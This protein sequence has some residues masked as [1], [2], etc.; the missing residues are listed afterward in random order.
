[1]RKTQQEVRASQRIAYKNFLSQF[2]EEKKQCKNIR[3]LVRNA[4][5]ETEYEKY[6]RLLGL[7]EPLKRYYEGFY[8]QARK[9]YRHI[10]DDN[11]LLTRVFKYNITAATIQERESALDVLNTL[12][13]TYETA[14]GLTQ[15]A[16]RDRDNLFRKFS[17]EWREFKDI[18]KIAYEDDEN[19]EYQELVGIKS[20]SPGYEKPSANGPGTPTPPAPPVPPVPPVPPTPPTV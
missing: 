17:K 1:L 7:D 13:K 3:L 19:P 2:S 20:Y 9:L 16:T 14:K 18:C 5:L 12:H 4:L 11:V 10:P 15:V 6:D 8:E